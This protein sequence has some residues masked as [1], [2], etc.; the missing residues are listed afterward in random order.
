LSGHDLD[1]LLF[2]LLDEF[3]YRFAT[4]EWI[5]RDVRIDSLDLSTFTIRVSGFGEHFTLAKHTQG[6]EIKAITY[7][8]MQIYVHGRRAKSDNEEIRKRTKG[9]D[10]NAESLDNAHEEEEEEEE[11]SAEEMA[12]RGT[13]GADIYVIVDI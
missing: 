2:T 6:T 3:L 5:V 4:N 12:Q 7:S 8:N 13:H 9:A 11:L 1:S 10:G